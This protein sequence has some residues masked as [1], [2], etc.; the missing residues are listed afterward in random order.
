MAG[1]GRAAEIGILFTGSEVFESARAVDRILL[2]KTG[3]VTTGSMRLAGAVPVA[4]VTSRELVTAA[5]AAEQGSEHP[6][7]RAI[8]AGASDRAGALPAALGFAAQPGAGAT[9]TVDGRAVRVGRPS[10]LPGELAAASDRFAADGL[11]TIGVW[12]EERPLGLIAVADAVKPDAAA[13]VVRL[14]ALGFE[15]ELVTGDRRITAEAVA[16][17]VGIRHV[18]AD[19]LPEGKI[20]IVRELQMSGRRVAFVGDGLNDAPALAGADVGIAMGTGTD[21]ALAAADVRVLGGSLASVADALELARRTYRVI[22]ENLFWAF[23]YNVVMIPLA[24]F[25]LLSPMLAAAAMALSSVSVVANALRLRRFEGQGRNS[26][27]GSGV[28][29]QSAP[30]AAR[31]APT[32]E[33]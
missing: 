11:T 6:I 15:P 9:A 8:V 13:A 33:P 7:A 26:A 5:G 19:I 29:H 31:V 14:R 23:A 12:M 24:A 3:T 28:G 20:A 30:S 22:L 17:D 32:E 21:V 18:H 25:G 1:T 10:G 4:G 27:G 2:D 16:R